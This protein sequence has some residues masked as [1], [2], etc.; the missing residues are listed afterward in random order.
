MSPDFF[1]PTSSVTPPLTDGD[2]YPFRVADLHPL[3]RDAWAAKTTEERKIE[4]R[5]RAILP[6]QDM[7]VGQQGSRT[8]NRLEFLAKGGAV[9][10][11]GIFAARGIRNIERSINPPETSPGQQKGLKTRVIDSTP[12]DAQEHGVFIEQITPI[13][14][15]GTQITPNG[16]LFI[17]SDKLSAIATGN[18]Q[19]IDITHSQITSPGVSLLVQK[20]DET[21]TVV[22]D[23]NHN[24]EMVNP[25]LHI[26]KGSNPGAQEMTIGIEPGFGLPLIPEEVDENGIAT[27]QVES[28]RIRSTG[29]EIINERL[30][31]YYHFRTTIIED[32]QS[33]MRVI[34]L[35]SEADFPP[36]KEMSQELFAA[37]RGFEQ[38]GYS[39]HP[40]IVPQPVEE[41]LYYDSSS[42]SFDSAASGFII[43]PKEWDDKLIQNVVFRKAI[44]MVMNQ[45]SDTKPISSDIYQAVN[46][47]LLINN[48]QAQQIVIIDSKSQPTG[49]DVISKAN[50]FDN[51]ENIFKRLVVGL[52]D[53][54]YFP[55]VT[56]DPY[57]PLTEVNIVADGFSNWLTMVA[58][59]SWIFDKENLANHSVM[60]DTIKNSSTRMQ[61]N[62]YRN[63]YEVLDPNHAIAPNIKELDALLGMPD[64]EFQ[65]AI[66]QLSPLPHT[67]SFNPVFNNPLFD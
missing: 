54:G 9:I 20:K 13:D 45:Y 38:A 66:S 44:D 47:I 43:S 63:L 40:Y 11:T 16:M 6:N 5:R 12:A 34:S 4:A 59:Y 49:S 42:P 19:A 30:I 53:G 21:N 64:R 56:Q 46:N 60:V 15:I 36:L 37:L 7:Q 17:S 65:N 14:E 58:C 39:T 25:F 26:K 3:I 52:Q 41:Y 1:R 33:P 67:V 48:D 22:R 27:V 28:S 61:Y 2:T 8:M 32:D 23:V 18:Q 24:P 51:Q 57:Y 55:I 10:A 50:T 62:A 29:N 35:V 31:R